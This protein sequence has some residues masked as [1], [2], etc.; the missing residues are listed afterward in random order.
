VISKSRGRL[1]NCRGRAWIKT[2][3]QL[4]LLANIAV[5]YARTG[6]AGLSLA[7]LE[8]ITRDLPQSPDVHL[9]PPRAPVPEL[10]SRRRLCRPGAR[11]IGRAGERLR[12]ETLC[13][14]PRFPV[15]RA[16]DPVRWADN[17][18][19][20]PR[21]DFKCLEAADRVRDIRRS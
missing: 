8:L 3:A 18:K 4:V 11:L 21:R 5:V 10:Q 13:P 2:R 9:F 1:A 19:F 20:N 14:L 6:E 16:P 7:T 15:P 17:T 12:E